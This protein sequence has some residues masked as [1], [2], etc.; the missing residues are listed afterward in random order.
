[1]VG[2]V[3]KRKWISL[4]IRKRKVFR[5]V[6]SAQIHVASLEIFVRHT[7]VFRIVGGD[8]FQDNPSFTNLASDIHVVASG[9]FL[10]LRGWMVGR[11]REDAY[12]TRGVATMTP[13]ERIW[14]LLMR[15]F[16][17]VGHRKKGVK[18]GFGFVSTSFR[19]KG[20]ELL[21]NFFRR[22][23]EWVVD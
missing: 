9:V 5:L 20:G 15:R 14:I 12:R 4:Q 3:I 22:G 2:D 19:L 6:G 18:E 17:H 7:A 21:V 16:L 11:I 23:N 10:K 13:L 8:D 1:M